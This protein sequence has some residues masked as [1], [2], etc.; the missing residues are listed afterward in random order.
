M[1][2]L[3]DIAPSSAKTKK[4]RP[5][6]RVALFGDFM[7]YFSGFK[8]GELVKGYE[9]VSDDERPHVVCAPLISFERLSRQMD[10]YEDKTCVKL[11]FSAENIHRY[12]FQSGEQEQ[13]LPLIG[14]LLAWA[15]K[16]NVPPPLAV[17]LFRILFRFR[18]IFPRWI[19][20][21]R[22]SFQKLFEE[23]VAFAREHKQAFQIHT[24]STSLP[25]SV[26][27]PYFIHVKN[28]LKHSIHGGLE[29]L[30]S[31]SDEDLLNRKFCCIVITNVISC[32][33]IHFALELSKY[34]HVDVM[35]RTVLSNVKPIPKILNQ[36]CFDLH[37]LYTEYKFVISFENTPVENYTTE[38]ILL[39]M[40]GRSIPIYWGDPL[41]CRFFNPKR[42][43]HHKA[44]AKIQD[45]LDQVKALDQDDKAYLKCVK[46]P[47]HSPENK[48]YIQERENKY[49][50][51]LKEARTEL[52]E[53]IGQGDA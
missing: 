8:L 48:L 39:A 22:T 1:S 30:Y 51:L 7:H 45:V 53:K 44:D 46:E 9:W 4:S 28:H 10:N 24:N 14:L 11:F 50:K 43:I 17:L 27:L 15:L 12:N 13:N 26:S 19:M 21:Y 29:D 5:K 42:F 32:Y 18:H 36:D 25:R 34:K 6:V 41:I 2:D 37:K 20:F 3:K 47:F 33:R 49:L 23:E 40:M 35:G 52:E 31:I 16:L 38:K